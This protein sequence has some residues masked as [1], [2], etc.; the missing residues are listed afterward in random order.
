LRCYHCPARH[1]FRALKQGCPDSGDKRHCE[2]QG[3]LAGRTIW[4]HID[5]KIYLHLFI[6][7]LEQITGLNEYDKQPFRFNFQDLLSRF[8]GILIFYVSP[9]VVMLG[10]SW[11]SAATEWGKWIF[12]ATLVVTF[13]LFLLYLKRRLKPR[14]LIVTAISTLSVITFVFFAGI[15]ADFNRLLYLERAL[16]ADAPLQ[17]AVLRKANLKW[18]NLK[19]ADLYRADLSLA[20]LRNAILEEA[21]LWGAVLEG[22]HLM[23][24]NLEGADLEGAHL[25]R[26]NLEGANLEGANL[27]GANLEG[28]HLGGAVLWGANLK[29]VDL[30]GAVLW[31][32]NL[33]EADLGR[34]YLGSANL[35]GA[36]LEGAKNLAVEQ[37]CEA[38]TLYE[39]QLDDELKT[40]VKERCPHLL[41]EPK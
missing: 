25:M 30:G 37:L 36:N 23:R 24:A 26:A 39:V 2:P 6:A 21:N 18:A 29:E 13:G 14:W 31:G 1:F 4:P 27:W 35:G 15:F 22:A 12:L 40:Q 17:F 11:K 38:K 34:A 9:V 41:E 7:K 20:D 3:L 8:L 5:H 16:L 19:N 33:K 32:A 28:A 10:F